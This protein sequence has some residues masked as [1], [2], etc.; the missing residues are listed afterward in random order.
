MSIQFTEIQNSAEKKKIKSLFQRAIPA[1]ERP[2]FFWLYRKR[3]RENVSFFN[4]YDGNEWVGA[5]FFS[6]H[7][8]LVYVWV[9]AIDDSVRS[10]GYGSAVFLEIRRLYPDHRILLG[11]EAPRENAKNSEQRIKRKQFY[12]R[13]G[14]RETGYFAKQ[15]NDSFELLLI[16]DTESFKIEE[17]FGAMKEVS[18]TLGAVNEWLGKKQIRKKE[19]R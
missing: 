1:H 10:K 5:V 15:F 7:K 4:V 11:I 16:G 8:S 6:V 17:F 2:P 18:W 3:K 13:N 14:F 12:E 9:F 19:T